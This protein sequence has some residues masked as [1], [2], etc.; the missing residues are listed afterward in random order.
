VE[1]ELGCLDCGGMWCLSPSLPPTPQPSESGSKPPTHLP[2]HSP[3]H[4]PSLRPSVTAQPSLPPSPSPRLIVATAKPTAA[5]DRTPGGSRDHGGGGG[6]SGGGSVAGSGGDFGREGALSKDAEA[7]LAALLVVA[8]ACGIYFLAR[9]PR[10]TGRKANGA[11]ALAA[12]HSDYDLDGSGLDGN[13]SEDEGGGGGRGGAYGGGKLAG[14]CSQSSAK[15]V[16]LTEVQVGSPLHDLDPEAVTE[17]FTRSRRAAA[18]KRA[19]EAAR[20]AA[21]EAE[22]AADA[23]GRGSGGG[24]DDDSEGRWSDGFSATA[25]DRGIHGSISESIGGGASGFEGGGDFEGI[26]SSRGARRSRDGR[27]S[28]SGGGPLR[29]SFGAQPPSLGAVGGFA[30]GYGDYGG[31]GYGG[32]GGSALPLEQQRPFAAT[33]PFGAPARGP[34]SGSSG[35]SAADLSMHLSPQR[36]DESW[37]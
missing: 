9:G 15:A 35:A 36:A 2:T 28:R 23:A 33:L 10:G 22:E 32:Y 5:V 19:G 6:G 37:A 16:E 20:E 14:D 3:T 17:L 24:G 12:R 13:E 7:G 21:R 29:G 31:G 34:S 11:A 4:A 25:G 1:S 27:G 26:R 30:T 18:E 8:L